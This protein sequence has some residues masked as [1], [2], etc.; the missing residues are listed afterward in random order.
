MKLV[1]E[2]REHRPV[3]ADLA[4]PP[5]EVDTEARLNK[6]EDAGAG[7]GLRRARDGIK[8][9]RIE[10]APWEAAKQLRQSPQVH[11]ARSLEQ[12]AEDLEDLGLEAIA[13]ETQRNQC[14]VV[15]PNRA[16]VIRHR[17]RARGR[18]RRRPPPPPRKAG[19]AEEGVGNTA[20][21]SR[22]S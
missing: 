20:R 22:I 6:C 5:I 13:G 16:V 8:C 3:E 14:I 12:P 1:E 4:R 11:I 10:P 17:G 21:A 19:A 15:R 9:R 2:F 7:P 18:T